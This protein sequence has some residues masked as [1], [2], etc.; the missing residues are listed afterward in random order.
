MPF[1]PGADNVTYVP[2]AGTRTPG[3]T[4]LG[5]GRFIAAPSFP[6]PEVTQGTTW[7]T[8]VWRRQ[9]SAI[10]ESERHSAGR[11]QADRAARQR[12]GEN[13]RTGEAGWFGGDWLDALDKIDLSAL[14]E[15]VKANS[16]TVQPRA[17]IAAILFEQLRERLPVT[18]RLLYRRSR[19]RP[20]G[21]R[22]TGAEI[23]RARVCAP[24]GTA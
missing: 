16:K 21:E 7:N 15:N 1:V 10:C 6:A 9:G 3:A 22:V 17:A 2:A 18:R 23:I 24:L 5:G 4:R 8:G 20:A 12:A 13:R 11:G 19:S 14:Y